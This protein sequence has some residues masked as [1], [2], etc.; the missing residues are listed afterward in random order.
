MKVVTLSFND[1]CVNTYVVIDPETY[2]CAIVDPGMFD[3]SG[4]DYRIDASKTGTSDKHPP[5]YRPCHGQ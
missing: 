1:F 3:T 2:E 5:A 4:E